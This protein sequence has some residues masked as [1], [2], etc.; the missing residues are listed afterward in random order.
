MKRWQRPNVCVHVTNYLKVGSA[1]ACKYSRPGVLTL[2][3]WNRTVSGDV[4]P[5]FGRFATGIYV[6]RCVFVYTSI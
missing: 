5:K 3:K 1:A 4:G 2:Y 6:H